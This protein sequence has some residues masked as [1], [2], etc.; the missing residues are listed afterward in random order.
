MRSIIFAADRAVPPVVESTGGRNKLESGE[1]NRIAK[2][3]KEI[4][5]GREKLNDIISSFKLVLLY[6]SRRV[7]IKGRVHCHYRI[8]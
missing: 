4:P 6:I 8:M 7:L 2:E 3:I 1:R 5:E